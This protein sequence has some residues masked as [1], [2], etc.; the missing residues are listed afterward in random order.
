MATGAGLS[1]LQAVGISATNL[2]SAGQVAG[3]TVI[4]TGGTLIEMILTQFIINVRYSLMGITLS[5]KLDSSFTLPHRIICS[6]GITDE[7]FA[8][9]SSQRGEINPPYMYGLILTPFIGWTAGTLLGAVAGQA[10]PPSVTAAMGILMYGMFVA[11]IVPPARGDRHILLAVTVA[12]ALSVLFRYILTSVPSGFA[13]II[14]ALVSSV[15]C[16]LLFP[17]A[18][19]EEKA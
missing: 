9:A 2:T 4:V 6:F 15:L 18:E 1:V 8:V 11:I 19:T 16:A 17:S 12:A 3:V 7:V 5:Q 13:V 14:S 10:L